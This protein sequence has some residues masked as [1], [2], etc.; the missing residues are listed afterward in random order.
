[1]KI[2]SRLTLERIDGD[3]GVRIEKKDKMRANST[4]SNKIPFKSCDY[5]LLS[6][7]MNER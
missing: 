7:M 6:N 3:E 1:M 5:K 4:N 2:K